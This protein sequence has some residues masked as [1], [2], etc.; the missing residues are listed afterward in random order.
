MVFPILPQQQRN[1]FQPRINHYSN[2][3]LPSQ[4][5]KRAN[6]NGIQQIFRNLS[7]PES[8]IGTL[9]TKGLGDLS[10]TLSNVDQVIKV[11]QSAT[12]IV[13]EYGPMIKNL[14]AMYRMVKAFSQIEE[15]ND[16]KDTEQKVDVANDQSI[17]REAELLDQREEVLYTGESTPRMY[18]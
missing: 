11:V 8:S 12:P 10:K 7:N 15:D 16:E 6:A 2:H 4:I 1:N 18:I 14:P 17:I 13:R 5:N 9:A 3:R